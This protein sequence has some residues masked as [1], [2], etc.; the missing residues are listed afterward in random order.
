MRSFDPLRSEVRRSKLVRTMKVTASMLYDLVECPRRVL[1]D[2]FGDPSRRD[3]SAAF[4]RLMWERGA[5]FE[6]ETIAKLRVPFLDLSNAAEADKEGL[7]MQAMAEG[8]PLIYGGRIGA[9]D[10]VGMPDLLRRVPGG[11]MASDV[12]SGRGKEGGDDGREGRLK[13]SYAV[14]LASYVDILERLGHSAGRRALV[15]DVRGDEVEYDFAGSQSGRK[16]WG[17]YE[18]A[19][20]DA[21]SI[22][23][24][25]TVPLPAYCGACKL[26]HWYTVCLG[27]LESADDLTLIAGLRRSDRDGM[28]ERIPSIA[29][30]AAVDPGEFISGKKTVFRGIG[31]DRLR[32]LHARAA[33]LKRPDPKPY[34]RTPVS[35]PICS[36]ELFFDVEV[37]PGRDVVYLHGV[38]ERQGSDERYVSFFADEP[39]PAAE[40]DAFAAAL[41]YFADRRDAR[42]HYYSK[43]ERSTYRR[44]QRKYPQVCSPEEV[45][46]LFDPARAVD[47]YGDVV[48]KATEWPTRDRS[49]KTLARYLGFSWR[50]PNPS[51]A[52]SIE[53]YDRWCTHRTPELKQRI[54]N[55]NQDDCCAT[56]VL[57]DAIRDLAVGQEM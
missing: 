28:R 8:A 45:E 39:T 4:V 47:L 6:R 24:G 57:L 20:A 36:V 54:L 23:A 11:Y 31:A 21:R 12:K 29:D 56:R 10:L 48:M 55:Y 52:A 15:L 37:D 2:L 51:G 5:R 41:A 14:Q 7:T 35:L 1:L 16:L 25:R 53:W 34:L 30:F 9:D 26:C 27:Q 13:L 32:A 33:L 19:L 43:Y 17:R 18:E 3:E 44:L 50:D 22:L 42:T 40:R 49:I 38:L 46:R